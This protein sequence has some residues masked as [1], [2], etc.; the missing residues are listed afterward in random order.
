MSLGHSINFNRVQDILICRSSSAVIKKLIKRDSLNKGGCV[1][2]SNKADR[3]LC[4]VV[5]S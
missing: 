1:S 3:K 4:T 5:M 2:W